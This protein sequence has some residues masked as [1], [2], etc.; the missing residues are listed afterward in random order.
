[1]IPFTKY[2]FSYLGSIL[3]RLALTEFCDVCKVIV[4]DCDNTLWK[5]VVGE[6][7][8][9]KIELS[10]EYLHFQKKLLERQN[11][12]VLLCLSSKNNEED[13]LPVFEK[14]QEM[15][16]KL[17]HVVH[18]EINWGPK[19]QS[20]RSISKT[21]NLNP[22][23]FLF[24]DDNPLEIH[25]VNAGCSNVLATRLPIDQLKKFTDHL[26]FLDKSRFSGRKKSRSHFYKEEVKRKSEAD[27]HSSYEEF[28]HSLGIKYKVRELD[29]EDLI[30]AHEMVLR[31]NQ[32][33]LSSRRH[34][35][36]QIQEIMNSDSK[37]IYIS[38]LEDRFGNYGDV[39]LYS[40]SIQGDVLSVDDFIISCRALGRGYEF[41]LLKDIG[42]IAS[43]LKCVK[44]DFPYVPNDRNRPVKLFLESVHNQLNQ[45]SAVSEDVYSFSVSGILDSKFII[46]KPAE[47]EIAN[48]NEIGSRSI[49]T[50]FSE[51]DIDLMVNYHS[52]V[53]QVMTQAF[54]E[55]ILE[56]QHEEGVSV[57]TFVH[58]YLSR[59]LE[60]DL[61]AVD[62]EN[63]IFDIGISSFDIVLLASN[64]EKHFP[65]VDPTAIYQAASIQEMLDK[66]TSGPSKIDLQ[67]K[68]KRSQLRQ[69][70]CQTRM[71]YSIRNKSIFQVFMI[72]NSQ[73]GIVDA[74]LVLNISKLREYVKKHAL[75]KFSLL[76]VLMKAVG[77]VMHENPELNV[78]VRKRRFY[79]YAH[80]LVATSMFRADKFGNNE[81]TMMAICDAYKKDLG[82]IADEVRETQKN[83]LQRTQKGGLE[84][85][86]F[87]PMFL[88]DTILFTLKK[89]QLA[90][91]AKLSR[92]DL[93]LHANTYV[94]EVVETDLLRR[95][96]RNYHSTMYAPFPRHSS[97]VWGTTYTPF[98]VN[99]KVENIGARRLHT[100]MERMLDD[101]S[102]E[103]AIMLN[104][105]GES[106]TE[107]IITTAAVTDADQQGLFMI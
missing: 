50:Y 22:D 75:K 13:V 83:F 20:I 7:G 16:I 81:L 8:P 61:S 12:G 54:P 53:S 94:T 37:K 48:S 38:N 19:S 40:L 92:E 87:I 33:N 30:R 70:P 91:R 99:E 66:L 79:E 58:K 44:I 11:E 98:E 78:I 47:E 52:N 64:L 85:L 42:K 97:I 46:S 68:E 95:P 32:F 65:N 82:N 84:V 60:K 21:L 101:I 43:E 80:T 5:G 106:P 17:D 72:K 1:M 57:E 96:D 34:D 28:I 55:S 103:S 23:S 39:G 18:R 10:G 9:E 15:A 51:E 6:L 14:R 26:I 105:I 86:K 25:E 74:E 41:Q 71:L 27:L 89:V 49:K 31:T 4:L 67:L 107:A 77:I 29:A 45:D 104:S 63:S 2:Y 24:I 76:H 69:H 35:K 3:T 90:L 56:T 100:I 73:P 93:A 102:F 59:I 36:D 62:L 88:W